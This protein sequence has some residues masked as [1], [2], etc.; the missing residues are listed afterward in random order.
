[1]G[2]IAPGITGGRQHRHVGAI[3]VL[4]DKLHLGR[5]VAPPAVGDHWRGHLHAHIAADQ[6]TQLQCQQVASRDQG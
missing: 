3:S 6:Q 1:M 2:G 4:H 5:I